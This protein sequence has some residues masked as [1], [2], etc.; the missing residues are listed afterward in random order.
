MALFSR[1]H[2]VPRRDTSTDPKIPGSLAGGSTRRSGAG[3]GKVDG[4]RSGGGLEGDLVAERFELADVVALLAFGVDAGVVEPGAQVV[5]AG[6]G[7]REQVPDDHQDGAAHRDDGPL[8]A[9]PSR[10]APVALSQ[11]GVG[12]AGGHGGLPEHAGQ[13]AVAVPGGALAL[14]LACRLLDARGELG[15][16]GQVASRGEAAM[17]VPISARISCAAVRPTPV[18]SSSRS[19]A[20]PKGTISSS[21]LRSSSAMSASSASTRASILASRNP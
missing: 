5:E 10:D 21:S 3:S 18:I 11:E 9:A 4:C 20:W 2:G 17:S 6:V 7:V 14:L 19:T 15:P 16:R 13:V 8:G 12:L 1:R